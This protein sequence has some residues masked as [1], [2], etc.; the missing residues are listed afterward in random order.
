MATLELYFD[1]DDPWI[2]EQKIFDI[3]KNCLQPNS[4]ICP[5]AAAQ[6]IDDLF[7]VNRKDEQKEDPGS[8]LWTLWGRFHKTAQQISHA[9]PA[10]EKMVAL[11]KA[12]RL[13][14]SKEPS[15]Q[16]ASWHG[17]YKIWE[18]L[19][20]FGPTFRE[21]IDCECFFENIWGTV[22]KVICIALGFD[23]DEERKRTR[24]LN[25]YAARLLRDGSV[26]LTLFAIQALASALEGKSFRAHAHAT[27]FQT[28]LIFRP[29]PE[30][31]CM[32][33]ISADWIFLCGG[34]L[35][36]KDQHIPGS[37]KGPLWE[38]ESGLFPERWQL[39]KAR[40][41][42]INQTLNISEETR[43]LAGNTRVTMDELEE[44][45]Q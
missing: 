7:P 1:E 8:F 5:D 23:N 22:G 14:S 37:Q 17:N 3:L 29:G 13:L 19:P 9:N 2:I 6:E 4:G 18:D 45:N 39:W 42:E 27:Q 44:R 10:Q 12:L 32:V 26:D 11:V 41:G 30:F 20:L 31:D 34:I 35:L 43:E 38:E 36:G 15:V 28:D 24:N 21:E 25:A 33:A 40:F 16:L